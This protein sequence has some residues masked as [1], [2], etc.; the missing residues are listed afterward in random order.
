MSVIGSVDLA[1]TLWVETGQDFGPCRPDIYQA[2]TCAAGA[3][4]AGQ[5]AH[6]ARAHD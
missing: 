5:G 6:A 3:D 4:E 2:S 1:E